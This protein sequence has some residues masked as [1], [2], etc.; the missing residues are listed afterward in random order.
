MWN[1]TLL[2]IALFATLGQLPGHFRDGWRMHGP[3]LVQLLLLAV[4]EGYLL[5]RGPWLEAEQLTFGLALVFLGGPML[6]AGLRERALDNGD[7]GVATLAARVEIGLL[8]S[9]ANLLELRVVQ[10]TARLAAPELGDVRARFHDLLAGVE[11][12][13]TRAALLERVL[14]MWIERRQAADAIKIFELAGMPPEQLS[15]R[16]AYSMLRAYCQVG[17]HLGALACSQ[18]LE[19]QLAFSSEL[20]LLGRISLAAQFGSPPLVEQLF[21]ADRALL[22]RYTSVLEPYWIAVAHEQSGDVEGALPWFEKAATRAGSVDRKLAARIALGYASAIEAVARG[23]APPPR[24]AATL[25]TVGAYLQGL[26][27]LATP[28]PSRMLDHRPPRVTQVLLLLNVLVFC[29]TEWPTAR[30]ALGL[31]LASSQAGSNQTLIVFG[32]LVNGLVLDGQYWRLISSQFLHLGL[33]HLIFNGFGLYLLGAF[34]ERLYGSAKLLVLYL[35]S[36]IAGS[37]VSLMTGNYVLSVGAS[38]AICGLLGLAISACMRRGGAMPEKMRRP[39]LRQLLLMAGMILVMGWSMA[40][41]DN[42]SHIG[43]G[44]AGFLLGWLA[45]PEAFRRRTP[46]WVGLCLAFWVLCS[47]ALTGA[48]FWMGYRNVRA[49]GYPLRQPVMVLRSVPGSELSVSLP[50]FWQPASS[51]RL[52]GRL[53]YR[54]PWGQ[55]CMILISERSDVPLDLHASQVRAALLRNHIPES[56]LVIE[57]W[58]HHA[59]TVVV[60]IVVHDPE[61]YQRLIEQILDSIPGRD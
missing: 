16:L 1:Q 3:R 25:R 43:G 18:L 37:V 46:R 10:L 19:R 4:L 27:P 33:L 36:G 61:R 5:W 17:D 49:G 28:R 53:F 12:P 55:P 34:V 14:P 30:S 40:Q 45:Y 44:V 23:L 29:L 9:P 57:N 52:A 24:P 13:R 50:R 22:G 7:L 59:R 21:E 15:A 2:L 54:E 42:G 58:R 41:I 56:A 8:W 6:L 51:R 32:A 11:S 20:A 26:G 47:L 38:G 60:A 35:A 39:M 31:E 48:T